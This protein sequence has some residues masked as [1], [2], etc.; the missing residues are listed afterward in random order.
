[1]VWRQTTCRKAASEAR[2][3]RLGACAACPHASSPFVAPGP[4]RCPKRRRIGCDTMLSVSVAGLLEPCG[5]AFSGTW[6]ASTNPLLI[7]ARNSEDGRNFT[8]DGLIDDVAIWNRALSVNEI[9]AEMLLGIGARAT[10]LLA[11]FWPGDQVRSSSAWLKMVEFV[12]LNTPAIS[13]AP[14][15]PFAVSVKMNVSVPLL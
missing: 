4:A 8:V 11:R 9:A 7:G 5:A 6:E 12:P 2:N 10:A 15:C 14:V 13:I 3:A 1:P